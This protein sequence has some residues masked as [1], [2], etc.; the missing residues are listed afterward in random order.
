MAILRLKIGVKGMLEAL[1]NQLQQLLSEVVHRFIEYLPGLIE[2]IIILIVGYIVGRLIGA[3]IKI[4]LVRVIGLDK[5]LEMK[6]LTDAAF[7]ISI[8][9]F[10]SGLIK[11][12]IYLV[13]I[14]AAVSRLN[15][16]LLAP[17]MY[18]VVNYLPKIIA[19]A[20]I[21][22]FGLVL[23]EWLKRKVLE[24]KIALRNELASVAKFV[25]VVIFLVT[26][27]NTAMV[28]ATP[29][30]WVLI[31]AFGGII[32]ALSIAVGIALGLILKDELRPYVKKFIEDISGKKEEG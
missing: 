32:L 11:W 29:I 17:Y 13:F 7:G 5:W 23:G 20:A 16:P 31:I 25:V 18:N 8:S 22:L 19:A 28:E 6:G 30:L 21:L 3:A 4:F 9:S 24:T 10:I 2:A 15:I 12:Y 27:L 26:A 1:L 14:G